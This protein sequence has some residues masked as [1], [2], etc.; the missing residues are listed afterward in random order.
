MLG[1]M[2]GKPE[3]QERFTLIPSAYLL[4]RRDN[5]VLLLPRANTGYMDGNYS[6]VAGHLE[7]DE[8]AKAAMARE[9]K[10]E[11]GIT[12]NPDD[13][14]LVHTG[15]RYNR[16]RID[17][18]FEATQWDGEIM[19]VEPDKCDDLSWYPLGKLPDTTIPFVRFVLDA[20]V[21]GL[22]YTEYFENV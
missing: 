22:I 21:R 20:V 14:Q 13:L 4:V 6:L 10:E 8:S 1:T 17:L 15:H 18:F 5:E 16:S 19:N 2:N 9:A 3:K 12:I 7:A 11:A